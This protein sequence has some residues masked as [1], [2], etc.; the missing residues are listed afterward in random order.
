MKIKQVG[1]PILRVVSEAVTTEDFEN[2]TVANTIKTMQN[3][4][5][6]I[7]A[8]SSENGNAISAPQVGVPIRLVVLRIEGKFVNIINPTF[9]T[10]SADTF[11]FEEECFSFYNMRAKVKRHQSVTLS[12]KN[13]AQ[14]QKIQTMS[15]EFAGLIQHE[16]DH[17]NGIFFLDKVEDKVSVVSI[18][19]LFKDEPERLEVVKEMC[20]YMSSP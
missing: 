12:Y 4:L 16:V 9:S 10:Q 13:E 3:I 5:N 1:D 17:L 11:M 7:Q 15:G 20:G 14:K 6:G 2:G 19:Y 8:I 18:D